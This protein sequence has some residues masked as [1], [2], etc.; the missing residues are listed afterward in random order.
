MRRRCRLL[1]SDFC[2]VTIFRGPSVPFVLLSLPFPFLCA[3]FLLLLSVVL[4]QLILLP[5]HLVRFLLLAGV[6]SGLVALLLLPV[7]HL[8]HVGVLEQGCDYR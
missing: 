3:F 5:L 2:S 4:G 1:R 7:Q 8:L 6:L